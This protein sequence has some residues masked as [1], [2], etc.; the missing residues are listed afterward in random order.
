MKLYNK[1]LHSL[2]QLRSEKAMLKAKAKNL[3]PFDLA[4]FSQIDVDANFALNAVKSSFQHVFST[5]KILNI[6]L[7]YA[8]FILEYVPQ[9]WKSKSEE[10]S[11]AAVK[12]FGFGYLKWKA[13]ELAFDTAKYLLQSAKEQRKNTKKRSS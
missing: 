13:I 5:N 6:A 10:W 2:D 1:Q 8:P 3:K 4:E 9:K 7:E 12:E 11:K